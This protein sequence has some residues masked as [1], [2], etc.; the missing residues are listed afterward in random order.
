MIVSLRI[1]TVLAVLVALALLWAY[2][3]REQR[4]QERLA[5]E[6]SAFAPT[7]V[8]DMGRMPTELRESSG[9]GVS[10]SYPGVFWTHNDSGDGPR[11]YAIDDSATLLATVTVEGAMARDW[12]AMDLGRC[13]AAADR[14]CLYVADIGDNRSQRESVVIYIIE[15]PDPFSGDHAAA[16]VGVVP[17]VYL[18]GPHDAEGLAITADGDVVVVTK[19]R[20]QETLLFEIPAADIIDAIASGGMLS[21]GPGR[22]LSIWPDVTASRYVT[23]AAL[24]PGGDV[25]AVRT[26]A[27]I[28][29]FLWPI[30]DTPEQIGEACFLGDAEPQGEAIGFRGDAED[31]LV[32]T[33]ESHIKQAGFLR[34][35]RC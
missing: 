32:L 5:A 30:G 26:Y 2:Q 34:A 24:S 13:P 14:S 18:D 9:L 31:W 10:Q 3:T 4:A 17:F 15:E 25:L 16:L 20:D 22:P 7:E 27:E 1:K 33:S 28:Y 19:E 21:L 12:E 11:L 6:R 8:V 23:G 29:R 35:V